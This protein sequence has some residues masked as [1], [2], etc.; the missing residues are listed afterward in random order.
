MMQK[1]VAK[2]G[3]ITLFFRLISAKTKE[4]LLNTV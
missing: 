3:K 1:A 4:F 2:V